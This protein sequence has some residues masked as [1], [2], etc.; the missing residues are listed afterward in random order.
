MDDRP[1]LFHKLQLSSWFLY[2]CQAILF[3]RRCTCTKNFAQSRYLTAKRHLRH[4][5]TA[6]DQGCIVTV[7]FTINTQLATVDSILRP[8]TPQSDTLLL[9]GVMVRASDSR[10]SGHGFDSRLGRYQAT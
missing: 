3:G 1:N 2:R 5:Y 9:G 4:Y 6:H 8:Q 7:A 10:S